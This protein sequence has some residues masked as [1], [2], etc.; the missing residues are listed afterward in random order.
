MRIRSKLGVARRLTVPR[1]D[2]LAEVRAPGVSRSRASQNFSNPLAKLSNLEWLREST[3]S[4]NLGGPQCVRMSRYQQR[5]EARLI[6]VRSLYHGWASH[7]GHSM[8]NKQ[9]IDRSL[10]FENLQRD[11]GIVC[12]P[13]CTAITA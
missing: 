12:F 9:Q 2:S 8:I 4:G 13:H 1:W 5:F 3:D 7:F 6:G 11:C 10:S